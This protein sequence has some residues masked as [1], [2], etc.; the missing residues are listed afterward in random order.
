MMRPKTPLGLLLFDREYGGAYQGRAVLV[1]GPKNSG[2]TLLGMHFIEQGLQLHDRCLILSTQQAEDLAIRAESL[3]MSFSHAIDTR[4]LFVLE[5]SDYLPERDLEEGLVLPPDGFQQFSDIVETEAVNRV[6]I[7]TILPWIAMPPSPRLAEHVFS[8]VRAIERLGATTLLTLP[9][10]VSLPAVKLHRMVEDV[11]PIS[12][13]LTIRGG[14]G[15]RS[16]IVNKYLGGDVIREEKPFDLPGMRADAPPRPAEPE[17]PARPD[18]TAKAA[19][20][21]KANR[22][23]AFVT[24]AVDQGAE[25]ARPPALDDKAK[26][27]G[28]RPLRLIVSSFSEVVRSGDRGT[29]SPKPPAR[30]EAPTPD[31]RGP[32]PKKARFASA[33]FKEDTEGGQEK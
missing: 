33:L 22:R 15:R 23:S 12:L 14:D 24:A 11:T 4:N 20:D 1:C 28:G 30:P 27:S 3:G 6:V 18:A 9:K 17:R 31:R 19:S 2:K 5:Y 10:P 7:D 16:W 32:P 8:F 13:Q 21:R 26:P 29:A 25:P